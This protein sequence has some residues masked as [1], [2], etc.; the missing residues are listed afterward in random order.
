V[1][2]FGTTRAAIREG[3]AKVR[4]VPSVIYGSMQFDPATRRV[5]GARYKR[6]VVQN[7]RFALWRGGTPS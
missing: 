6:L 3:L 4:G 1:N 2:Q 5:E 7:G